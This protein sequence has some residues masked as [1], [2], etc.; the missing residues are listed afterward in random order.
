MDELNPMSLQELK[1]K[2]KQ[3]LNAADAEQNK[4]SVLGSVALWITDHV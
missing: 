4:T 3:I 1:E 2:R